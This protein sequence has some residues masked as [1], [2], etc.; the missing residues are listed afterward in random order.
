MS[1]YFPNAVSMGVGVP[2]RSPRRGV[3]R[4]TYRVSKQYNEPK[5][6]AKSSFNKDLNGFLGELGLSEFV[7]E[8]YQV[9][10]GENPSRKIVKDAV[11]GI[12][13]SFSGGPMDGLADNINEKRT[14]VSATLYLY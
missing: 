3:S 1:R 9:I 4:S 10:E 5:A 14:T 11:K 8:N 2:P 7:I 13:H 12:L 6:S